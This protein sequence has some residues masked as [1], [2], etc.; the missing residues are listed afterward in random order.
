MYKQSD[1]DTT[2]AADD[3]IFFKDVYTDAIVGPRPSAAELA[4]RSKVN[5][6][7]TVEGPATTVDTAWSKLVDATSIEDEVKAQQQ[8]LSRLV[9]T[10]VVFQTKYDEVNHSFEILSVV[11]SVIRQ[12]D[13]EIRWSAYAPVAQTLF[14]KA[15][16]S[17]RTGA[18][19]GFRYCKNRKDDLQ[20]LVRGGSITATDSPPETIDWSEAADRSPLMVRL[21]EANE[22]L[23]KFTTNE[24]SFQNSIGEIN[25]EANMIALVARVIVLDSMPEAEEDDYVAYSRSML[26]AALEL[27]SSTKIGDFNRASTAANLVSQ[28]CVDCHA[29]WR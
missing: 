25:H 13:G 26:D 10:P 8:K 19:A 9:T 21:E 7:E 27:K 18:I 29:D 1:N 3:S 12:Y 15:A 5:S 24:S 16:V 28:S 22:N 11:F 4:E 17:A 2:N 23:K 20:E 14:Q 6:K